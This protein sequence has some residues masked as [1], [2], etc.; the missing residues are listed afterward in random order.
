MTQTKPTEHPPALRIA[1][2]PAVAVA[3]AIVSGLAAWVSGG[4]L[5]VAGASA[6]ARVGLLPAW[7][8][9]VLVSAAVI[10]AA[11]LV[12]VPRHAWWTT[13]FPAVLLLPWLPIP[14]P[15]PLLLWTGPIRWWVWTGTAAAFA[16]AAWPERARTATG[17]SRP[18]GLVLSAGVAFGVSLAAFLLSAWLI[19]PMLPGGDEPHYLVIAQSLLKDGDLRI[20]NNHKQGDY[21]AYFPGEL[22]PDY[23]RRGKDRQIYSIHAPGL[24]AL[25]APAF[26]LGGYPAVVV[27]LSIV[28]ALGC[29]LLWRLALALTGSVAAAWFGWAAATVSTPFF[30]HAFQVFPDATG[31]VLALVGVG[32]LVRLETSADVG[33]T[34]TGL[35]GVAL[36]ALPWL[37]TRYAIVAGVLGLAIVL[38]LVLRREW[39][40]ALVFALVPAASA[41][42]WLGFFYLVYG[43]VDP[44][45]PY[46]GYTQSSLANLP[47]GLSGLLFDQQF[48]MLPCAPVY[49]LALAGFV[50]LARRF[51]RLAVEL[52]V[53]FAVYVSSAAMYHM[54]WGGH[55]A[56]AR[57]AVPV[58]LS[59]GLPAAAWWLDSPRARPVGVAALALTGLVT[60]SL[61]L[62]AGGALVFNDRNGY[63]RWLDWLS[64]NTDLTGALPTLFRGPR[65][66]FAAQVVVWAVVLLAAARHLR[67][68]SGRR[69]QL[70]VRTPWLLAAV[71]TGG[72]ALGW[73]VGGEPMTWPV[74]SRMTLLRQF[75]PSVRPVALLYSPGVKAIGVADVLRYLDLRTDAHRPAPPAGT[76]LA[77]FDVP[78]GAYRLEPAGATPSGVVSIRIGRTAQASRPWTLE[79]GASR[80]LRLPARVDAL[81]IAGDDEA[82]RSTGAITLRPETILGGA[83]E[84]RNVRAR[85]AV[86]FEAGTVY[87]LDDFTYLEETGLWVQG[88][89]DAAVAVSAETPGETCRLLVRNGAVQNAVHLTAGKWATTL[90]LAPGTEQVVTVPVDVR[91]GGVV[92]DVHAD[93]GFTP[94]RTEPGSRDERYLGVWLEPVR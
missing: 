19:S 20:E 86:R 12:R 15:A 34:G 7:P 87:A 57:F 67:R 41:A 80:E 27:F 28:A 54:W 73:V 8:L 93:R 83:D 82:L 17:A 38:R 89:V 44:T 61:A 23:L 29:A 70:A 31:A 16:A 91:R 24:P 90:S 4:V 47:R 48:G 81:T 25:V 64:T 36:A 14:M 71:V 65:S 30:F 39:R 42:A 88:G 5:A 84:R 33:E 43:V 2:P 22:R 92:L 6:S 49:A 79:L 51:P 74:A 56:A 40:R 18:S 21:L 26:A 94:A 45:A 78:A 35:A 32:A 53:L 9:P 58:L 66:A 85:R 50:P 37:H 46:G 63:A 72:A 52:G 55:S 69:E 11:M 13:L 76:L 10:A 1:P 62:T 75:D 68:L 77:L 60:A 59:L 3:G